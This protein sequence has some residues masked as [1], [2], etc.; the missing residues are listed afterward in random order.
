[1]RVID[2][3]NRLTSQGYDIKFR[4]RSKAE[5]SGVRITWINGQHF[6][7]SQ[8]NIFARNLLGV[9]MSSLQVKHLEQIKAK[10][11]EF[12]TRKQNLLKVEESTIKEIKKLQRKFRRRGIKEGMP[13]IRNYRYVMKT[14]GKA[15]AD[16]LLRQASRY[17][18]G[19]AYDKNIQALIERMDNDLTI[20]DN[21][22]IREA[23]NIINDYYLKGAPEFLDTQLM[24]IYELLYAWE[25]APKDNKK[26]NDL[27]QY[28]KACNNLW[29]SA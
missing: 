3:I 2:I 4:R 10:K 11:G 26:A 20:V 16:R 9:E 22:N 1:M 6:I 21:S 25:Q 17:I 5:G 18:K 24:T 12:G 28:V 8:G 27:L 7:G 19:V 15:E 13:S 23:R 29:K 14:Y